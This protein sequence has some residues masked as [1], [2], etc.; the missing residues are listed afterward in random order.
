M[1]AGDIAPLALQEVV[2]GEL[3]F[4]RLAQPVRRG[5][6]V[7]DH[8]PVD[9]PHFIGI[10]Y[11]VAMVMTVAQ[12]VF[13]AIQMAAG[14]I[15]IAARQRALH[16]QRQALQLLLRLIGG[17]YVHAAARG[18][19]RFIQPRPGPQQLGTNTQQELMHRQLFQMLFANELERFFLNFPGGL[20]EALREENFALLD[21]AP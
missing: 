6:L 20:Q 8:L 12:Q 5:G 13:Q 19:F 18:G 16:H 9:H 2:I 11:P 15:Q 4:W 1:R 21:H 14:V 7:A 3:R 10:G 17:E